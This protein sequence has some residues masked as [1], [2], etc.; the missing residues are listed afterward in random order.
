MRLTELLARLQRI[1]GVQVAER[2]IQADGSTIYMIVADLPEYPFG[3]DKRA[4]YPLV[5]AENVDS[6]PQAEIEAILRRFWH[7]SAEFFKDLGPSDE[8]IN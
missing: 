1:K 3:K 2:R 6:V 8:Q 7:G 5:V 4:W